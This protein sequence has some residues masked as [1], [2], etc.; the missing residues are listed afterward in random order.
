MSP[1]ETLSDKLESQQVEEDCTPNT[2]KDATE[3]S[4]KIRI[5][6]MHATNKVELIELAEMI[7]M[8]VQQYKHLEDFAI[9]IEKLIRNICSTCK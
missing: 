4:M 7:S 9:F 3:I 5:D 6:A 1:G 8:K 2:A